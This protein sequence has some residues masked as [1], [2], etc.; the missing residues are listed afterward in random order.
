VERE[1]SANRQLAVWLGGAALGAAAMYLADPSQGRRRRAV[2]RDRLY[3]FAHRANDTVGLAW[4][5]AGNRWN[6]VRAEA[7]RFLQRNHV[8]PI[9]DHVLEARV[10][11]RLGRKVSNPH[12]IHVTAYKGRL[13]LRGPILADEHATLI[14]LVES[15]PGVT[16]VKDKLDV[17]QN[18]EH[19]AGLQGESQGRH[20]RALVGT[21]W[22]RTPLGRTAVAAACGYYAVTRRSPLGLLAAFAGAG[23]LAAGS[24]RAS[25]RGHAIQIEKTIHI[26]AAPEAIFDLWS[27]YDSFPQFM[28]NVV[29]VRDLGDRRSHWVVKGLAGTHVEWDSVLTESDR[30]LMLAWRSEQGALIEHDGSVHLEPQADG[31]RVTV[32][33]AYRPPAGAVGHGVAALFGRDP[34]NELDQDLLRMKQFI[35]SGAPPRDAAAADKD[36][37]SVLH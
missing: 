13:E 14:A 16:G 1:F 9:D 5:D 11:T 3:S 20:A 28:E 37:G 26:K 34:R 29:E 23:L 35:E 10:R 24:G 15:I 22:L 33:M 36:Q 18:A 6:G 27:H 31:T 7:G 21:G 30:P 2:A 25:R 32:R 17:Q 4:R 19:V 8:K 12:S